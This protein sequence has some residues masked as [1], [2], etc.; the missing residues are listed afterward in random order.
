[1][2]F[3]AR[4]VTLTSC[5]SL[6]IAVALMCV[7]TCFAFAGLPDNRAY[8]M[9]SPV[10][11]G[12][13]VT[14]PNLA[15]SDASGEHVIV[16]GGVF[17]ALLSNG[18]SWMDETRTPT[19]W[20][21]VQIGP[22]PGSQAFYLEQRETTLSAVSD[23][24]SRFA[25]QTLMPL[26][27][28]DLG[29]SSDVYVRDGLTG[30]LNWVSAPPAPTIKEE[31]PSLG[32]FL[33]IFCIGNSAVIAG[34]SADLDDVVWGQRT[35]LVAPPASLPGFPPDTHE[36]GYELYESH[37]GSDQLVGLVPSGSSSECNPSHGACVVPPCGAA[38]GNAS[39]GNGYSGEGFATTLGAVSSDGS[40]VV[41]TSPDPNTE[42]LAGCTPAEIYVRQGGTSTVEASA[43]QKP[44]GD[45]NGAR[46]K[47]YVGTAAEGG[48]ITTV[49]FTSSEELTEDANTG[50]SDQG[51]DLYAYSF[52]TG[53]LTDITAD[54]NPF[55][56][57]GAGVIS[58]IGSAENGSRVY[59]TAS[60]ALAAG[61]T[62]GQS[63]LYV[64]DATSGKTT[65]IAPGSG[66][67][68][69]SSGVGYTGAGSENLTSEMTPDGEHL[70]F[71]S[72]ERLTAYENLGPDCVLSQGELKPGACAE[73]YLYDAPTSH[74]ACV[75]CSPEGVPPVG[76]ARLPHRQFAEGSTIVMNP[77]TLPR[78]RAISDDGSRVFFDSPD[79]L[80]PEAPTPSI[81]NAI[82][83]LA[84]R[85][86]F[87]PNAYEYEDGHTYLIAPAAVVLNTTPNGNDVFIST[88]AQLVPQD[89]DGSADVYDARVDGGFP[90]L[91]APACS[92]TSCQGV[93]SP[94][95]IFAT[96]PSV[97]FNGMGN[98]PPPS[99]A[100]KSRAKSKAT[101]GRCKK[102]Y[103]KKRGRCVKKSKASKSSHSKGRK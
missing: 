1:M 69:P 94:S 22:A 90:V 95:P 87:E 103:V 61:A 35:P 51:N 74:L 28:H 75:S 43:S 102:G 14:M 23:D 56:P 7:F 65:F 83:V 8:E 10:E 62:A 5:L 46:R 58:F 34:A 42:S 88:F 13:N 2:S 63:N 66:I 97:T 36:H 47:T 67:S 91:A 80:T 96:P 100:A 41:F 68:G 57:S 79:Q 52:A 16:D 92:G 72:R 12:G 76:S 98:F 78:P 93:P 84:E 89:R 20:S 71:V 101:P 3:N 53:K 24:F 32:C 30:P 19:G 48:Q 49:F 11:K 25:F 59:F 64:Y 77:G 55:D 70:A 37:S 44:G 33:P 29:T 38:M 26:D 81:T 17:N 82:E 6:S 15:F 4:R 99:P 40:Q 21:G 85:G 27:P 45:P 31:G 50:S 39:Y 86:D 54:H 9:V 73:V 18:A 60:G